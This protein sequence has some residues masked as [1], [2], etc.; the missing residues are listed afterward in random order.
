MSILEISSAAD[1]YFGDSVLSTPHLLA[2]LNSKSLSLPVDA[3]TKKYDFLQVR[4]L[5]SEI[6]SYALC[7]LS[8]EKT[9]E[10]MKRESACPENLYPPATRVQVANKVQ[11]EWRALFIA[12]VESGEL[13]L[14]S[15]ISKLPVAR[16]VQS[17]VSA[18]VDLMPPLSRP[19]ITNLFPEISKTSWRGLFDREKENGLK[20]CR[21]EGGK[22]P[23]YD[24]QKLAI[25]IINHRFELEAE[26]VWRRVRM[27]REEPLSSEAPSS[28]PFPANPFH[29]RK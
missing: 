11:A 24:A 26:K 4:A 7:K 8:I 29:S 10:L 1:D 13:V 16:P 18:A 25:W 15:Y 22:K 17:E 12:G 27:N 28:T 2:W 9:Y 20:T 6:W 5:L 21:I 19:G 23:A 3:Y 14:L